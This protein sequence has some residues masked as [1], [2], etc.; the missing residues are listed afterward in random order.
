MLTKKAYDECF[1][2][3]ERA[4]FLK[5]HIAWKKYVE[6]QSNFL[7]GGGSGA[8]LYA[9][10]VINDEIKIRS[11][12]YK[13]IIEGQSIVKYGFSLYNNHE[14]LEELKETEL[15]EKLKE[16]AYRKKMEEFNNL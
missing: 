3:D 15:Y 10:S 12:F 4:L 16:E 11:Q 6:D 9:R 5:A 1:S 13:E 8:G 2:D 7:A 14:E